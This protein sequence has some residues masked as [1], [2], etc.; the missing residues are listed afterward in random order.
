MER[1]RPAL[2]TC[3]VCGSKGMYIHCYY[4]RSIIDFMDGQPVSDDICILRL[5]CRSCSHTHAV[6]PDI[7]VP[8]SCHSLFFILRVLAEYFMHRTT[9]E[10]LCER[11]QITP[12]RLYSWLKQW[13]AQKLVWL[14]ILQDLETSSLAFL[15]SLMGMECYSVFASSFLKLAELSFL[16]THANPVLP[17]PKAADYCQRVFLPD[18]DFRVTT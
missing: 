11:F 10:V 7:I 1:F 15:K 18:Y 4:G 14:G 2:E 13:N 17:D 16:Q 12:K 8:Y 5:E 6:L 3:P 9:L